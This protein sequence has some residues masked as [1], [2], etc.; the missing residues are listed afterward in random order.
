MNLFQF[1][2][3]NLSLLFIAIMTLNACGGNGDSSSV[4]TTS[5]VLPVITTEILTGSFIDSPV[6]GLN[7]ETETQSGTTD[8]KG[9]FSYID[10]ENITFSIGDIQFPTVPVKETLSPLDIFLTSDTNDIRVINMARFL[11]TLDLDGVTSNGITIPNEAHTQASGVSIDFSASDFDEQVQNVVANSGATI[12]TLINATDAINH[13]N[14]S[15]SN[16]TALT[17]RCEDNNLKPNYTGTFTT[18]AYEVG[19]RVTVIDNCTL[20]LTMFTYA[21]GGAPAVQLYAGIGGDFM[22]VDAFGFGPRLEGQTFRNVTMIVN[23]PSGKT[24]ADFD[25]LSVWC[26]DF[27]ADFGSLTLQGP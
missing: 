23:L 25:S 2:K 16:I 13:L 1:K 22:G 3:I 24:V 15:L 6:E 11:Q 20:E 8:S 9:Y 7:Y 12:T 14:L 26:L 18:F 21:D 10:G 19:G 17:N 5:T 27:N 4:E